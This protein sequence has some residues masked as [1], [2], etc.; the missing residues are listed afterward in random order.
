MTPKWMWQ[1]VKLLLRDTVKQYINTLRY[2]SAFKITKLAV[3]TFVTVSFFN[4]LSRFFV[5]YDFSFS[6][7]VF[8]SFLFILL[9]FPFL[10]TV[11]KFL[12]A[13]VYG[14]AYEKEA[15]KD[16]WRSLKEKLSF[17]ANPKRV[18]LVY[19]FSQAA[20]LID[21]VIFSCVFSL[22]FFISNFSWTN[23]YNWVW[24]LSIL[25]VSGVLFIIAVYLWNRTFQI[26]RFW[27]SEM[28]IK[29]SLKESHGFT[30]QYPRRFITLHTLIKLFQFLLPTILVLIIYKYAGELLDLTLKIVSEKT[31]IYLLILLLTTLSFFIYQLIVA[32]SN[33]Y[34]FRLANYFE[35]GFIDSEYRPVRILPADDF[36]RLRMFNFIFLCVWIL[37]FIW[38]VDR[39]VRVT[40][41]LTETVSVK[42]PNIIKMYSGGINSTTTID[43][44]LTPSYSNGIAISL[45]IEDDKMYA[46]PLVSQ[47]NNPLVPS[48]ISVTDLTFFNLSQIFVQ[49]QVKIAYKDV[50][51]FSNARKYA[52]FIYVPTREV[53]DAVIN[54]E[55]Q[56]SR[57]LT[58][59]LSSD[60]Q[61]AKNLD[62]A[63]YRSGFLT[64]SIDVDNYELPLISLFNKNINNKQIEDLY[65][66]GIKIYLILQENEIPDPTMDLSKIQGVFTNLPK[67][68]YSEVRNISKEDV[69]KKV[70][71]SPLKFFGF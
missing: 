34:G 46:R 8:F 25:L 32:F 67:V 54:S 43:S 41:S 3:I 61:I 20:A 47:M 30:T 64:K 51:E 52:T 66:K 55:V 13:S 14:A 19:V 37:I 26:F 49:D 4:F 16:V 22:V 15:V 7:L 42:Y 10:F 9:I 58:V 36:S 38:F 45:F 5:Y 60:L 69:F 33:V 11:E 59:F 50:M 23:F 28:N 12:S 63:G 35:K 68:S 70:I 53:A 1:F 31:S 62:K 56:P 44:Y 24:M 40:E 57:S 39:Q 6:W 18:W 27:N 71:L 29:N 21:V 2:L 48:A 65:N 17:Y